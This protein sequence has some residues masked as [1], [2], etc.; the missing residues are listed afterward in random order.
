MKSR[1][2]AEDL[3][4]KQ[5]AAGNRGELE[6]WAA[7]LLQAIEDFQARGPTLEI[8]MS[9]IQLKSRNDGATIRRN[10]NNAA[11]WFRSSS[12]DV[13]SFQWICELFGLDADIVWAEVKK[14][15]FKPA[16]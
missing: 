4:T 15:I 1:H 6:L 8:V 11:A 9:G 5:A 10:R 16:G 12:V 2:C 14:K 3:E 7:V 13:G